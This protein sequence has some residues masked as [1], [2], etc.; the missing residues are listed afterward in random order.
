M[1]TPAGPGGSAD[2]FIAS[3]AGA[4]VATAGQGDTA[5]GAS[6]ACARVVGAWVDLAV[7]HNRSRVAAQQNTQHMQFFL[8]MIY[9]WRREE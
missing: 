1:L 2:G 9:A 3:P 5:S 8:E 7:V 4:V 6:D